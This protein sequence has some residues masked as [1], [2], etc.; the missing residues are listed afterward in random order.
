MLNYYIYFDYYLEQLGKHLSGKNIANP[1]NNGEYRIL[2]N[3]IKKK[4]LK[5][6]IVIDAGANTGDYSKK[7]FSFC[8]KYKKNCN[9]FLIECHTPLLKVIKKNLNNHNYHLI[10]KCLGEKNKKKVFFYSDKKNSLTGQNSAFKHY[11]LNSKN[12]VQQI[13]IDNLLKTHKISQVNLLKMDIEGS[14]YNALLG[15]KRSL[16]SGKI[17]YVIME[18]NQTWIKA[19]AKLEDIFNIAKKNNYN[20]FRVKK[21]SLLSIKNYSYILDDFSYSHLLMVKKNLE[22]PLVCKR[23]AIPSEIQ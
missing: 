17:D 12:E 16:A 19:K 18:Y 6:F 4:S 21:N 20:L 8:K 23:S 14:E 15:S 7:V 2:E 13:T 3:L 10:N 5:P 9:L 11:Y 22:L 1:E